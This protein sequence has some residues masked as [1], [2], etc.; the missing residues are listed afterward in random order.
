MEIKLKTEMRFYKRVNMDNLDGC[1]EWEGARTPAGYGRI[2]VNNRYMYAH[3]LSYILHNDE[4]PK[5][6]YVCHSCDNPPCVNPKHLWLGTARDN[7]WDSVNKG[8]CGGSRKL[9]ISM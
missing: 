1:W 6:L 5:G 2:T 4:I 7:K 8:R 3:R 9:R